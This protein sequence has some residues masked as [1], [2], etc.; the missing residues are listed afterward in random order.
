MLEKLNKMNSFKVA[1]TVTVVI[2]NF[3]LVTSTRRSRQSGLLIHHKS[4]EYNTTHPTRSA[5]DDL[6]CFGIHL[7]NKCFCQVYQGNLD[8]AC[9]NAGLASAPRFDM[10]G[11]T[12]HTLNLSNNAI[13]EIAFGDFYGNNILRLQLSHNE[14]AA[15]NNLAFWGLE[16]SLGTLNL[17]YNKLQNVPGAS[18]R[19]LRVLRSLILTG[20]Q[21]TRIHS[22]AFVGLG[23]LEVFVVDDNPITQIDQFAFEGTNFYRLKLDRIALPNGAQSIPTEH[24]RTLKGLWLVRN[25]ITMIPDRWFSNLTS[26]RYVDLSRNNLTAL[27]QRAFCN[28]SKSLHTLDL[29]RNNF[30][31]LP[32][33]TLR[34]LT[35]LNT[36]K[37]S[38]NRIAEL[39][40]R[41]FNCSKN[42]ETLDLSDNRIASLSRSAFHGLDT[43][44]RL[45][46]RNNRILTLHKKVFYWSNLSSRQVFL[47]GNPFVCNC[48]LKWLKK[49]HRR[50]SSLVAVFA[51]LM[52]M[53]CSK[54][55]Y[56]EGRRIVRIPMKEFHCHH[57]Y[58]YY[59]D[60]DDQATRRKVEKMSVIG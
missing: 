60:Y 4:S 32:K 48:V 49:E 55:L 59:Y 9:T 15:L 45:D 1:R 7:P 31:E 8:I 16:H 19:V 47:S 21:I 57:E 10:S 44:R 2:L 13:R 33:D 5:S 30:Q 54:P 46:L 35:S 23:Q 22:Y 39:P 11:Q 34:Y 12:V 14:I 51:D 20:N 58:Y 6:D 29:S 17:S 27:S 18:L 24:L 37:M 28:L 38:G 41:S 3:A 25:E 53:R 50:S 52:E 43:L 36:L 42:L 40:H 56:F 26:L